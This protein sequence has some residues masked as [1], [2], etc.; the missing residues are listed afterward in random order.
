MPPPPKLAELP[1]T[2]QLLSVAVPPLL[3]MPPPLP[4]E[5]PLTVQSVSVT[6]A[7]APLNRPPPRSA[8]ALLLTAQLTSVVLPRLSTPAPAS[9]APPVMIRFDKDADTPASMRRTR[10]AL[11]PLTDSRF[12]PG[13][14]M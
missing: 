3:C 4:V 2:V 12:A 11:L 1:L 5:L 14:V 7:P 8:A 13:P 6:V 10:L 9:A